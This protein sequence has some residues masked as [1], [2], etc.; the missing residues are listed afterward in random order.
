MVKMYTEKFKLIKIMML[1]LFTVVLVYVFFYARQQENTSCMGVKI[2]DNTDFLNS[3]VYRDFSDSLIFFDEKA[4][5]DVSSSTIYISQN[6]GVNSRISDL[7]GNLRLDCTDYNMF[8]AADSGFTNLYNA[9]KAGHSFDLYI[10]DNH[11]EYMQYK[12]V[13][14]TLPVL[15]LDGV[16]T[17]PLPE[18][19]DE[20]VNSDIFEGEVCIWASNDPNS[21]SYTVK[22]SEL[23]WHIRGKTAAEHQKKPYKLSLKKSDGSINDVN[24]LGLGSDDDW[25]LN[26]LAYDNTLMREK[27]FADLWNDMT[28]ESAYNY[29]MT[30]GEYVETVIN[31]EYRGVYSIMRRMDKKF[32]SLD[33]KDV[34]LKG[35]PAPNG[36]PNEIVYCGISEEELVNITDSFW[37]EEDMSSVNVK[38]YIDINIFAL[39]AYTADNLSHNNIF[40]IFDIDDNGLVITHSFWDMDITFGKRTY[41]VLDLEHTI[42]H[43]ATRH[44][45]ESLVAIYPEFYI[46]CLSRWHY[47]RSNILSEGYIM[48][49]I[50]EYETVLNN[51]GAAA[52]NYDKWHHLHDEDDGVEELKEYISHRLIWSDGYFEIKAAEARD[53]LQ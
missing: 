51:S 27:L 31:G 7:E 47:L 13:F 20:P 6:I 2:I 43:S 1:T 25:I 26:A 40:Y 35:G 32:L 39:F 37:F 46:E 38:N 23:E 41:N 49:K 5:V 3:Y 28:A 34:L 16:L 14:T 24:F 29:P 12:V 19:R 30:E 4:A 36:L 17:S 10:A 48:D 9:V 15:K 52:R 33:S 44:D 8:F 50:A 18:G 42:N 21:R 53:A 11:G 45:V 22:S